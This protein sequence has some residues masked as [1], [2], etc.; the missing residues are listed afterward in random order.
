MQGERH[1][2]SP[3]GRRLR[4]LG[5]LRGR[6]RRTCDACFQTQFLL[7]LAQGGVVKFSAVYGSAGQPCA[8]CSGVP[9]KNQVVYDGTT[10]RVALE[11]GEVTV[12]LTVNASNSGPS[13]ARR[14]IDTVILT[15]NLT[16]LAVRSPAPTDWLRLDGL[17]TQ[18]GDLFLRLH[19]AADGVPMRALLPFAISHATPVHAARPHWQLYDQGSFRDFVSS[20]A[21]PVRTMK[22][23]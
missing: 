22:P 20:T 12:S 4:A 17:F 16:D 1:R 18:Q 5:S 3:A 19:N 8:C 15:S 2:H 9:T 11:A 13:S 6:L 10:Q 7:A 14:N 21:H 23:S